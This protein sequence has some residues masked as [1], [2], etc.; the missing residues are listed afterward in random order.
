[1]FILCSVTLVCSSRLE[2]RVDTPTMT[3][4]DVDADT[5]V[6]SIMEQAKKVGL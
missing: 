2:D 3:S 5:P 4:M 6:E 1:M